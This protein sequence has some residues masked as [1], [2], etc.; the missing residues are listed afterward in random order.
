MRRAC[1]LARSTAAITIALSFTASANEVTVQNDTLSGGGTGTIQ[2]GFAEN[3]SAAA[4]LTSPCNGNIVAVQVLWRSSDGSTGQSIEDSITIFNAG[5]F[6]T[7]GA[8]RAM[9]LGPVMNDGFLNEFRYLDENQTIPLSVPVTAGQVFVVSFRFLSNPDPGNGPSVVTD[10]GC[11]SGKNAINA[12]GLGW[13]SSCLLG[14]SGDFVIRAVIDCTESQG[15]CCLPNGTCDVRTQTQCTSAGGSYRGNNTT[16]NAGTCSGACCMNDGTCS[17]INAGDCQT[18]GGFFKGVATVCT[19]DLCKG[20]CC[21]PDGT[22]ANLQSRNDCTAAGGTY[23][24]DGTNCGTVS[25]TGACCY[26]NGTCQQQTKT[27]CEGGGGLWN[28][29]STS[30]GTFTCPL[31]GA[32]CLP[33]GSCLNNKL[34]TECTALGGFYKGDNTNCTSNPCTGGCCFAGSTCLN[35]TK[36]DCNQIGGSVWQGPFF[37]CNGSTCPTGACCMPLGNCFEATTPAGC[38]TQGGVYH[39]GQTCAQANCPIPIGAC[40]FNNGASCINNLQPGQCALIGGSTWKGPNSV[41]AVSCCAPPMGDMNADTVFNS[42]DIQQFCSAMLGTP[43]SLE[44]C[45]GDFDASGTLGVGDVS[46]MVNAL[47][48]AP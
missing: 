29:P 46:G 17:S 15:A 16:C 19:V 8:Q 28:G 10:A 41:C 13:V 25:C 21:L 43:T 27:A 35:L 12:L 48:T 30:C 34:Q 4:W 45:K 14:V 24:G 31:R 3:E 40:C 22:C 6:P 42:L 5:T 32:C 26:A 37:Q 33:D 11:Q 9:L 39:N 2:A 20:A 47:L 38:A 18:A 7:P 1:F 36:T 23:K 44:I